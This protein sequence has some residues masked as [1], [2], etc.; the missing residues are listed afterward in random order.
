LNAL[1]E[2]SVHHLISS[3]RKAIEYIE[4]AIPLDTLNEDLYCLSMRAYA[5]L[6]DRSNVARIYSELQMLLQIELNA[7]PMMET[8]DLYRKLMGRNPLE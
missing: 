6:G 1:Q 8:M 2:L 3:P 7:K 5:E 4:K